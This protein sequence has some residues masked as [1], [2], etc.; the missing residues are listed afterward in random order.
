VAGRQLWGQDARVEGGLLQDERQRVLPYVGCYEERYRLTGE[1]PLRW[2]RSCAG[3]RRC[4]FWQ[5]LTGGFCI[6]RLAL[7]AVLSGQVVAV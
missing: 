2:L 4:C 5:P 3:Y 1:S 6:A 7:F